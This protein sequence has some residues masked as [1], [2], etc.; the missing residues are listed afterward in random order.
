MSAAPTASVCRHQTTRKSKRHS[1]SRSGLVTSEHSRL[2]VEIAELGIERVGEVGHRTSRHP[3]LERRW[4]D[5]IT[6]HG[7]DLARARDLRTERECFHAATDAARHDRN[8]CTGSHE[9]RPVEHLFA[10]EA[11]ALLSRAL[12][13]HNERFA[14]GEH[15]LCRPQRRAICSASFDREAAHDGKEG[16]ERRGLPEALLAH[17]P[18]SSRGDHADDR[19]VNEGAMHTAEDERP[20]RQV[21]AALD[22]ESEQDEDHRVEDPPEDPVED[23]LRVEDELSGDECAIVWNGTEEICVTADEAWDI[24]AIAQAQQDAYELRCEMGY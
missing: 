19:R 13:K 5:R 12:R 2:D 16:T 22:P 6:D 20:L 14:K 9:G 17:E 10:R 21:L 15:V 23:S 18:Q 24:E 4:V 3:S 1:T 11:R 7:D 8:T